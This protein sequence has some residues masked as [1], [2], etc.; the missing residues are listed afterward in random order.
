M[1]VEVRVEDLVRLG[2]LSEDEALG[3]LKK[4]AR[5]LQAEGIVRNYRTATGLFL[6]EQ[7]N[8]RDCVFLGADRKCTVYE[9][10]PGVCRGFPLVLGPRV[11]FCPYLPQ[12]KNA[13]ARKTSPVAYPSLGRVR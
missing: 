11:G 3:S 13:P 8:G 9:R 2:L 7:K 6:L 5:R 10:R 12:L 4:V 1:P